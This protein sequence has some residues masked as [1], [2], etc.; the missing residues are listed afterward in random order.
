MDPRI[1]LVCAGLALA[2]C[3]REEPKKP[4][5]PG[6]KVEQAA[7][8]LGDAARQGDAQQAGDAMK[9]MGR[10]SRAR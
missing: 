1:V 7:K 5:D 2:A 9:Q 6:T 10:R 3:G 8:Q 4:L